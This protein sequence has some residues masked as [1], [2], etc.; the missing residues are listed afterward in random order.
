MTEE[1]IEKVEIY[2]HLATLVID[3]KKIKVRYTLKVILNSVLMK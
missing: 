1:T 3:Y 2:L